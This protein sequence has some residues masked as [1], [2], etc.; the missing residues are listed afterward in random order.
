MTHVGVERLATG[1]GQHHR[2]ECDEGCPGLAKEQCQPI[3]GIGGH[4]DLGRLHDRHK[5]QHGNG[6]KPD[7]HHRPEQFADLVGP[8]RLQQEE[9]DQDDEGHRHDS[10]S[11]R[12]I[13]D[14]ETFDGA[15]HRDRRRQHAVAVEQSEPDDGDDADGRFRPA[16]QSRRAMRQCR[17]SQHAALT[18]IVRAHDQQDVFQCDDDDQRP[19]DQGQS[20][21]HGERRGRGAGAGGKGRGPH[22]I[23]RARADVAEDHAQCTERQDRVAPRGRPAAMRGGRRRMW[24]RNR[25]LEFRRSR[26]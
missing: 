2:A 3:G 1:D 14:T 12:G 13:L 21:H 16:S 7:Q 22:G 4:E 9:A 24:Q 23:E 18:L 17:E 25:H 5:A 15:Q 8:A 11:E 20:A 10:G 26:S 6:G 19:Q